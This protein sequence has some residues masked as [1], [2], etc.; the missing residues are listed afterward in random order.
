MSI[1]TTIEQLKKIK[2]NGM[3][4]ALEELIKQP[5]SYNL[6]FEERLGI[7]IDREIICREN[8]RKKRLLSYAKLR[9]AHACVEDII[10]QPI[11]SLDRQ[12]MISFSSCDWIRRQQNLILTGSTG[13]GKTFVACALGQQACRQGI[14]VRYF[15]VPRL[16]EDLKIAQAKGEYNKFLNIV[17]KTELLI[18][19]DWGINQMKP[20]ERTDILEILEARHASKATM[21]AAQLPVPSWHE[22]IGDATIADAVLDRILSN[23]HRLDIKGPSMR[24]KTVLLD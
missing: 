1:N 9:T 18:L 4:T 6:S 23:A 2:L 24:E 17:S 21:I 12:K 13:T 11:R 8:A 19:D 22:Y 7:L 16:L 3:V 20:T 14:S 15:R 5:E 10:Y